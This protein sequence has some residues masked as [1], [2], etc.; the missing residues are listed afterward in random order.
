MDGGVGGGNVGSQD[1]TDY[2]AGLGNASLTKVTWYWYR[3]YNTMVEKN[4]SSKSDPS[5]FGN[6]IYDRSPTGY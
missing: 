5:V 4:R 1:W 2:K 6:L 3:P